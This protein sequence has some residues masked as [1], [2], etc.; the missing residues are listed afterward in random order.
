MAKFCLLSQRDYTSIYILI[1]NVEEVDVP[2]ADKTAYFVIMRFVIPV[3]FYDI[4]NVLYSVC[5]GLTQLYS[6][7][8][9]V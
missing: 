8:V 4:T 9:L 3:V 7:C 2:N 5:T 1:N 6:V